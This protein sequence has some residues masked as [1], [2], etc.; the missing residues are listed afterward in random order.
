MIV[1]VARCL[2]S[3]VVLV[4]LKDPQVQEISKSPGIALDTRWTDEYP[5]SRHLPFPSTE[6]GLAL[7]F[8][9]RQPAALPLNTHVEPITRARPMRLAELAWQYF[10]T[11]NDEPKGLL[12]TPL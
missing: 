10:M 6:T 12:S 5:F 7:V 4:T 2:A 11:S 9:V 1:S 3:D 8:R